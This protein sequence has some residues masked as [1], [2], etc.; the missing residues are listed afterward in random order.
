MLE[1]LEISVVPFSKVVESTVT[2]RLD[3]EYFQK[4]HLADDALVH[5]RPNDFQSFAEMGLRV[6][7]S[8]FYPA[9]EQY[10]DSGDLPFIR[11]ADVD[12]VIDFQRCT[13]I[14]SE[15]CDRFPTLSRVN[16]GDIVFTKGGSVARIGLVTQ[17]AAASRDLIFFDSAKLSRAEQTFLYVYAQTRFFNRV[18]VRSSSQTAQPH[19]TITLV[20]SL[21]ILRVGDE[22]KH[23]CLRVVE[24]AFEARA[25]A[26]DRTSEAEQIVTVALGLAGWVPPE[27]LTYVA[28]ATEAMSSHRLDAEYYHP[29]KKA[30]LARLNAFSGRRLDQHY[31]AVR[32]MF[33]P[34]S[35]TARD[36]VRNFDLTDALQPVLDDSHPVISA[37]EVGSSKKRLF[38]GDVVISRLRA[39]LREIALVRT[40]QEVPAVGSSEF[41]VLRPINS[42]R[43]TLSRATL[44]M[45]LRSDPVQTILRWSQDGS[46]HPRF[47]DEDLMCIPVPHA[48]CAVAPKIEQLFEDILA[49][50]TRA[51]SLLIQARRAV[52]IAIEDSEKAALEHLKEK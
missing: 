32:D 46:H 25:L 36:H 27:P 42:E 5:S 49:A 35:A 50:R 52:E 40:T 6:D 34:K 44:L 8:A 22:L 31:R 30:I 10:Y 33:D 18:L 37:R 11:V 1:G 38:D 28:R 17:E 47:G 9:I 23:E 12:A 2:C 20:R 48:V 4:K 3:P 13:R 45:F 24:S 14:P 39:Y 7:G 43:P 41:I 21:P 29:A 15:L 19:L 26:I 16:P 51:R